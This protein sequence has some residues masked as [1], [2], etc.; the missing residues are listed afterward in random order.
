[1]LVYDSSE[2]ITASEALRHPYLN[3]LHDS[4]DEPEAD[5]PF[6]WHAVGAEKSV[7][8]WKD[9]VIKE[10]E[11]FEPCIDIYTA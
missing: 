9:A 3:E 2:R 11:S 7:Q 8:E 1:M 5:R 6:D 4:D 10:V